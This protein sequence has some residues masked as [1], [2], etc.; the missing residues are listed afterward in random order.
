MGDFRVAVN[1][2]FNWNQVD[3]KTF[4][5]KISFACEWM[6]TNFQIKNFR[7]RSFQ[8]KLK[9]KATRKWPIPGSLEMYLGQIWDA[10]GRRSLNFLIPWQPHFERQSFLQ[11]RLFLFLMK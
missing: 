10:N 1:L 11:I 8:I 9:F 6:K 3:W 4:H 5:M 7:Q 2:I